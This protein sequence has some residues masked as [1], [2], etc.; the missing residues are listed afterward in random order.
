M[1]YHLQCISCGATY[2]K[3][4]IRY[5]CD[6]CH[7]LL[8]VNINYA[9]SFSKIA[10]PGIWKYRGLLP[11]DDESKIVSL[12]EGN[13]PSYECKN[14]AK[15]LHI[16]DSHVYVKNEGANPTG[17]FKDRGMTLGVTKALEYGA[18]KV[19]CASTGN[20]SASMAAYCA[21]AGIEATVFIPSGKIAF[22]KLAQALV[23]GASVYE[24]DGSFDDAMRT[25][26]DMCK[27]SSKMY[28]LNSMNP[29]RL[30]GQKTIGFEIAEQIGAVDK[31][32]VPVGNAANIAAIWKGFVEFKRY[33][34]VKKLPQ[35]IGVQA[36]GAS[37]VAKFWQTGKFVPEEHPETIAS[38]IRI[39]NP[40]NWKKTVRA[41]KESGGKIFSVTDKEILEAQSLLASREGIFVEPASAASIAGLQKLVKSGEISKG[42]KV[43]CVTTG[44]GLKDPN[45]VVDQFKGKIKK[46]SELK[47]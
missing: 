37:P 26:E 45:A 34:M 23:Y 14:L 7:D 46:A 27:D 15:E 29:F 20:T 5:V 19:G 18:K 41:L 25:V 40:V 36:E 31:V 4:E 35:M 28:L 11:I 1:D 47:L 22:G 12:Q 38:A 33:H 42:E 44:N 9:K 3:E 24:V 10:L 8:D 43:V 2:H 39:G 6:K 17:S 21:K 32:I 13:T 16:A 30:E